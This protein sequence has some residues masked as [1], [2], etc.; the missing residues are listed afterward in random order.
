MN[1]HG[2]YWSNRGRGGNRSDHSGGNSGNYGS[3]KSNIQ[4]WLYPFANF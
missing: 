4:A 1:V 3:G 2:L